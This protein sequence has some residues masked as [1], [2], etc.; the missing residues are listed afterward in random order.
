MQRRVPITDGEYDEPWIWRFKDL[1]AWWAN[2]HHERVGG[3][4]RAEPTAWEPQ[5]KPIRFTEYGCAAVDKGSNEPNRFLDP[6][7]SESRLPRFSTGQRD[8]LMQMQYLRAMA[9]YWR[10]LLRDLVEISRGRES[11]YSPLSS[12]LRD[13]MLQARAR[14]GEEASMRNLWEVLQELTGERALLLRSM[15]EKVPDNYRCRSD[16]FKPFKSYAPLKA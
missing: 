15:F 6:K 16:L 7:S 14:L 9:G 4:R 10:D 5:S 2:A 11:S 3:V 13:E 1:R 12:Q 8:D